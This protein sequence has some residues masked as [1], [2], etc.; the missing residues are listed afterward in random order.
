M[1][2]RNYIHTSLCIT[3]PC[4][5][6]FKVLQDSPQRHVQLHFGQATPRT[7]ARPNTKRASRKLVHLVA[8]VEAGRAEGASIVEI[9][10]IARCAVVRQLRASKILK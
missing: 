9:S 8:L 2:R 1:H 6:E 3:K 5:A 7:H 10:L 4:R